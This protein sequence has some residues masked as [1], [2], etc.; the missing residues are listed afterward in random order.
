M[1]RIPDNEFEAAIN[2]T[3]LQKDITKLAKGEG[4]YGFN[5]KD[6]ERFMRAQLKSRHGETV[7][8]YDQFYRDHKLLLKLFQ[9]LAVMPITRSGPGLV[10]FSWKSSATTYALIFYSLMTL[11]VLRIGYERVKI[12]QT[13]KEFDE[14]IYAIIFILFLIPHFWIPFVG[15]GVAKKVAEYKTMWGHFQVRYY[16]VT[17]I[18]LQ[19]PK[20]KI[21]I[22][23]LFV[24]CLICAV[25]FLLSLSSMLDGYPLW[26]TLA[27]YHI[28][29]MINMNC[30]LWYINSRAI[31]AA[32]KGLSEC[33][34]RDITAECSSYMLSQYR[35]L[36][37]NLSELLQ[38]LGTAYARTYSTYIIFM[39]VNITIAIYGA[40][41]D[42]FDHGEFSL[43]V[44]GLVVCT[45]YCSTLLFIFCDCSHKATLEVAQGVQDTLLSTNVLSIDMQAQKEVDLFIQA[46]EMNPAIVNLSGYGNVNRELLS[47]VVGTV[48]IYLIVLLQ[49]K[50]TL[51]AQNQAIGVQNAVKKM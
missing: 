37:L 48:A 18:T 21:L 19:F 33:F 2:G 43:K 35:F 14:Y 27:Y 23:I 41:S 34:K 16:R 1:F 32:S 7:E 6:S 8:K 25:L 5:G 47:S 51:I 22:V 10:T 36:W 31:K 17:N 20:L 13:T 29:T 3:L 4:K 46:I 39:S 38:M 11:V 45:I 28:I 30:S 42:I 40:F 24:G 44:G 50:L 15:W 26:H 9:L 49:F 12:L